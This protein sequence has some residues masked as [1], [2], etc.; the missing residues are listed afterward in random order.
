MIEYY[1][2]TSCKFLCAFYTCYKF[3]G[4][5][6]FVFFLDGVIIIVDLDLF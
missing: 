3:V 5:F 6:L 2:I 4:Q 1:L